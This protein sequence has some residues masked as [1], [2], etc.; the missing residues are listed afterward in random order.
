[1]NQ[2]SLK[3]VFASALLAA[4]VL[5]AAPANAQE[6]AMVYASNITTTNSLSNMSK[7]LTPELL[8]KAFSK[9][10]AAELDIRL[11]KEQAEL[12]ES[13]RI[14]AEFNTTIRNELDS[15]LRREMRN[16]TAVV[17]D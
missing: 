14:K 6:V 5:T 16:L 3:S 12:T 8:A 1:M 2:L 9:E 11:P 17:T 7:T 4:S 15:R 13:L 10:L